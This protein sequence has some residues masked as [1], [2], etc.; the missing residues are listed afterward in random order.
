LA[1]TLFI[2]SSV[3]FF[4][5]VIAG[6]LFSFAYGISHESDFPPL[7]L[8]VENQTD[9]T[10]TMRVDGKSYFTVPPRSTIK[11]L[12]GKY[13]L[14][15]FVEG[16]NEN[17]EIVYSRYLYENDIYEE[18]GF[19]TRKHFFRVLISPKEE[20]PYLFLEVENRLSNPITVYVIS[21]IGVVEPG[22]SLRTRPLPPDIDIYKIEAFENTSGRGWSGSKKIFSTTFSKAELEKQNWK[23][24]IDESTIFH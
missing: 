24:V 2:V 4:L 1:K 15:F 16:I 12:A 7:S 3:V 6:L 23:L 11:G 20:N 21:A 8:Q 10:I 14:N 19:L 9:Q 5:L 18:V 13:Y 22:T 17:G